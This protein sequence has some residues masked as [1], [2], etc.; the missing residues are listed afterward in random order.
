MCIASSIQ[1]LRNVPVTVLENTDT[2]NGYAYKP[3]M[4][5]IAQDE[6][7]RASP[8]GLT[9][10]ILKMYY[11]N[12]ETRG[13]PSDRAGTKITNYIQIDNVKSVWM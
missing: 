5:I 6:V 1:Q 12:D 11:Y 7:Y 4:K 13:M 3:V 9:I 8:G 10:S 2:W